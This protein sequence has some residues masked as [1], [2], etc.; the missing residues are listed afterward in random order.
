MIKTEGAINVSA[1]GRE[2]KIIDK[3]MLVIGT[4]TDD[5]KSV[6]FV[7]LADINIEKKDYLALKD[8]KIVAPKP[9]GPPRY[10]DRG[11]RGDRGGNRFSNP[12]PQKMCGVG[13]TI[14]ARVQY[15]DKDSYTLSLFGRETGVIY[16]KC[17]R[18]GG[19]LD[20][21]GENLLVCRDCNHR[22]NRKLSEFYNKPQEITKLFA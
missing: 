18:C 17:E 22:E 20:I 5:M 8:G 16:A 21:K 19:E 12:K 14:L 1:R 6:M 11:D 10:G 15:N 7:K 2:I 13:D 9:R 3:D 4:V